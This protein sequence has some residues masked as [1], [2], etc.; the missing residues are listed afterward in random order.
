MYILIEIIMPV[1]GLAILGFTAVKLGWFEQSGIN[2]LSSFVF[3]FAIPVMLFRT[4]AT[5]EL[6]DVIPWNF[7]SAYYFGALSLFAVAIFSGRTFFQQSSSDSGIFGMGAAYSNVVLMGIPLIVTSFGDK[8]LIPLLL[9]VSTHAA[10]MFFVTTAIMESSSGE[11]QQLRAL[12]FQTFKVLAKNLIVLGLM[13]GLLFNWLNI[14]IPGALDVVAKSLGGAAL[15]CAVFSMGASLSQY[16]IRG[17]LREALF[18]IGLKNLI[19]PLLV[20]VLA[21]LVF[22]LEP[23]WTAVAVLLAACPIGINTY[24]F[25]QRYSSL[26]Q[27]V[28]AAVLIST[29]L[30]FFTLS[31]FLLLLEVR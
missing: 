10:V 29:G 5:A 2:G 22:Q 9:I 21:S 31:L 3:N 19:H 1:F 23:L 7:L 8:A 30:S 20:W 4:V 13:A 25:A 12:P 16:K 17:S 14:P 24:L 18:L 11:T 27:P 28:A 26:V 15:P 6:P